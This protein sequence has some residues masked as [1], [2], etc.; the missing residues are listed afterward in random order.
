[1]QK[2]ADQLVAGD[3]IRGS[4]FPIGGEWEFSK[5][6]TA[7]VVR[8]ER[9]VQVRGRGRITL[10]LN[11]TDFKLEDF[12]TVVW[13]DRQFEVLPKLTLWTAI[14]SHCIGIDAYLFLMEG[15]VDWAERTDENVAE[16]LGLK[17]YEPKAGETLAVA[18]IVN[19]T[20][21]N[22]SDLRDDKGNKLPV[23]KAE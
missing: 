18:P 5:M 4:I 16:M 22:L 11:T 3:I 7:T 9:E 15:N 20:I 2:R 19:H 8:A 21:T 17:Y 13:G 12:Y 1:M 10:V 6:M 14:Y 23:L